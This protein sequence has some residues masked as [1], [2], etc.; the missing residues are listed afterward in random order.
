MAS[1]SL[2]G[3][4]GWPDFP[5]LC[6]RMLQGGRSVS[7]LFVA[8][9]LLEF[10]G[11]RVTHLPLSERRSLLGARA[12]RGEARRDRALPGEPDGRVRMA[13]GVAEAE[14]AWRELDDEGDAAGGA[15]VLPVRRGA[16]KPGKSV[17]GEA[18]E[19]GVAAGGGDARAPGA[20]EVGRLVEPDRGRRPDLLDQVAGDPGLGLGE[21]AGAGALGGGAEGSPAGGEVAVE[22]DAGGVRAPVGVE[23][24]RVQVLDDPDADADPERVV[25]QLEGDR[26]AG[27]L[28]AVD[29][30]DGEQ[31]PCAVRVSELVDAD[32]PSLDR[33]AED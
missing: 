6:R 21:G 17:E 1:S 20:D 13:A 27:A 9:D 16:G 33:V 26:H 24:V 7:V 3:E 10:D 30:A 11:R 18:D 5:R 32:R 15:V 22:V 8:F 25:Q 29:A 23:A 12:D 14:R 28:V 2:P 31:P 19:V 4:D